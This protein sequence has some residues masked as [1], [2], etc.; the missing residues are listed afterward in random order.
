MDLIRGVRELTKIS[1]S[2][3]LSFTFHTNAK[4]Q[5]SFLVSAYTSMMHVFSYFTI[6][7]QSF[8]QYCIESQGHSS[9][10]PSTLDGQPVELD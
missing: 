2:F 9:D 3:A 10:L 4:K 8:I 6:F 7:L 1:V 5:H